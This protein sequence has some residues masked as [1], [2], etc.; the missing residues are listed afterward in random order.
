MKPWE[1]DTDLVMVWNKI[2]EYKQ[3]GLVWGES[4]KLEPVAFGIFKLIIGCSLEDEKISVDN[5]IVEKIE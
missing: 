5:D 4:Y 2:K 1:A 3:D